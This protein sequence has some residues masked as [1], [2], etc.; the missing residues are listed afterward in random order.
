[1]NPLA[2]AWLEQGRKIT[3]IVSMIIVLIGELFGNSWSMIA[4]GVSLL[5]GLV[6]VWYFRPRQ[7]PHSARRAHS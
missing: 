5:I 2:R 1:M 4:G 7:V 6:M 3:S